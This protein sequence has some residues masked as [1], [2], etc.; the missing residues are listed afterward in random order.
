LARDVTL[1][2]LREKDLASPEGIGRPTLVSR[3]AAPAIVL[4]E[5]FFWKQMKVSFFQIGRGKK[6][7][8]KLSFPCETN[9]KKEYVRDLASSRLTPF[10]LVFFVLSF[11]LLSLYFPASVA[12]GTRRDRKLK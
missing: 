8:F 12:C 9:E 3:L 1:G 2:L 6:K 7:I 4:W 5:I 10:L 11:F